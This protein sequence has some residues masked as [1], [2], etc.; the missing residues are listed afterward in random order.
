[1]TAPFHPERA[2]SVLRHHKVRFV[3]IGGMAS[4]LWGSTTITNDLDICYARDSVNLKALAY[5]LREL[6]ARLRGAPES[7]PFILEPET[8]ERGDHFTFV[9]DA[10]N[11][12]CFGFP[13][14]SGGFE[15]LRRTAKEMEIGGSKVLVADLEDLIRMKRTSGR[16][17]DRIELEILGALRDEIDREPEN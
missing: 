11:L 3:V 15:E 8:L 13:A 12:D 5:A 16:P 4:R 9:T 2:L 10:G 7:V 14:G 6:G 17:K 1:M